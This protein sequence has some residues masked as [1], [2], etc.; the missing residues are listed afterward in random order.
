MY[1]LGVYGFAIRW[2]LT[3]A[4]QTTYPTGMYRHYANAGRAYALR[5]NVS[6]VHQKA[7][8]KF[9]LLQILI[10]ADAYLAIMLGTTFIQYGWQK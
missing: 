1:L 5:Y 8:K 6:G 2:Y 10:L 9:T 3:N 4:W 7:V